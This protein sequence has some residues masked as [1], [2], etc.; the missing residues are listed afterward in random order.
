MD[1]FKIIT[2]E[3][4]HSPQFKSLN[5]LS[6][7]GP[8]KRMLDEICQP[9]KDKDG[10][11][12]QQ[13]QTTAFY[14]RLWE[15]FLYSFF[16]ENKF[17]IIDKHDRP[18]FYLKK[19]GIEFFVEACSS[20]PAVNDKFTDEFIEA[21]MKAKDKVAE[22]NLK[23][24]YTIKIGSILFS[25]VNKRYWELD[26]VKYKPFVLAL[27]PSHNKLANFLPDYLAIEYLYGRWFKAA[28]NKEGKIEGT[29]GVKTE[30]NYDVKKIPSGFF[31]QKDTENIS[32]VIFAN[33]CETQKFNRM[34]QQGKYYDPDLIIVRTGSANNNAPDGPPLY[35]QHHVTPGN[36]NETW[37]EG[38][39]ILHN[40]NCKFPLDRKL[41]KG[42]RQIWVNGEGKL[43][44]EMPD[45]Y[46]FNSITGMVA[47]IPE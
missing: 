1:I 15:I 11:F 38:V 2:K 32:A 31:E 20:N 27:M 3:A 37:S 4:E 42:V 25:K 30:H 47:R 14:Q 9:L 29:S 34:G 7:F 41:F 44:G 46:P 23:D 19:D 5:S 22:Q 10:N 40:P 16:K 18:D 39:S 43:D 35:F 6:A 45:F 33:T 26:W 36:T 8:A 24:Y 13:F 21:S 28:I 17:E 12:I